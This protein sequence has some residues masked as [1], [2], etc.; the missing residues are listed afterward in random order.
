MINVF[1]YDKRLVC[2]HVVVAHFVG[3]A[4]LVV[5]HVL[6]HHILAVELLDNEFA[7]LCVGVDAAD[8]VVR[9]PYREVGF[10]GVNHK[11]PRASL[12]LIH[13][14]GDFGSKERGN[15]VDSFLNKLLDRKSVV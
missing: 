15:L 14:H 2:L 3:R 5:L 11:I 13:H 1:Y 6:N 10:L 4:K 8:V 9:D 12:I 7:V